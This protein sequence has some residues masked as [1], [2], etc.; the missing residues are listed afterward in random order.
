MENNKK[1]KENCKYYQQGDLSD[2]IRASYGYYGTFSSTSS[3]EA[4]SYNHHSMVDLEDPP[5]MDNF[6]DPFS[7]FGGD[8]FLHADMMPYFDTS[9]WGLMMEEEAPT[10]NCFDNDDDDDMKRPC[11]YITQISHDYSSSSPIMA[12]VNNNKP[13]PPSSSAVVDNNTGPVVVQISS[14]P[15]NK[16]SRK[17]QAKKS[18]CI[19]AAAPPSN[20]QG[21]GEVVP[22]DLWAWRKYGQKPIKGSPYPRGYYRCSST[23]GCPARKQVER[24]RTDPNMLVI[25]YTCEHNHSWPITQRNALAGSSRSTKNIQEQQHSNSDDSN[26]PLLAVKQEDMDNNNNNNKVEDSFAELGQ[27]EGDYIC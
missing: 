14:S 6:G 22:S 27:V 12:A 11:H 10:A 8:P 20:R 21:V 19:P 24:S 5:M 3:S 13:H 1:K 16:P 9:S 23:K 7:N 17:N 15:L 4:S 2:I 25:T 26:T 18:I